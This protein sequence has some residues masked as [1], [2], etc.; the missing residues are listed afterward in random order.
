FCGAADGSK[1]TNICKS[2]QDQQE[3]SLAL[4]KKLWQNILNCFKGYIR[5]KCHHALVV[6]P[7]KTVQFF[8]R[9]IVRPDFVLGQ[10][11]LQFVVNFALQRVLHKYL[12]YGFTGFNGLNNGPQAKY[13]I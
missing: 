2:V 8:Y 3:R 11:L 9:N 13:K 12:I 10:Q 4:L 1:V 6:L 7:C 5:D